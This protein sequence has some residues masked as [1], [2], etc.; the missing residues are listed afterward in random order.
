MTTPTQEMPPAQN[1]PVG[2]DTHHAHGGDFASAIAPLNEPPTGNEP[3]QSWQNPLSQR[4]ASKEMSHNFSNA[5]RFKT[6]R[7]LWLNL[8]IA[9]KELGLDIPQEAIDQMRANLDLDDDQMKEASEEERKTRHDVMAH[10]HVFKRKCPAAE[11]IIHLGVTSCYVTDNADLIFIK[12]AFDL[13]IP[14]LAIAISRLTKFAQEYS[15]MPTLGY[16][17]MQPAQL[18]TV[19]KRACLWIQDLLWDLRNFQRARDDLGFRGVKGTTGTQASFMS[20]FNNDHAKIK[21]LD[22]RVT[23]LCG[24]S[25]A[26]PVTGQT[27]SRKVDVDVTHTL[28]SFSS[29]VTKLATDLRHLGFLQEIEEPFGKDQ[30]GSSAMPYK[31]NPMLSERMCGLAR[32]LGNI[33]NNARETAGLMWME[34]T[35]DD[36]SNRRL[37]LPEAFLTA[38]ILLLV[39]QN[40]TEGL[41]VYPKM[42]ERHINEKLPYM[43]SENIIMAIVQAGGSRQDAHEELRV[44]SHQ[45]TNRVKNE[46]LELDLVERIRNS[47][48]FAPIHDQLDVLL[49]PKTFVG[50]APEQVDDFVEEWVTPALAPYAEQLASASAAELSV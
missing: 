36:S 32:W 43:A 9:Q 39:L 3:W 49:D 27:Y 40:V 26:Y 42:I 37:V 6:W 20:L 34:R 33:P 15:R 23:Q 38:D 44:L 13:I 10:V 18:T 28:S 35:L 19:G 22:K 48:F 50:R 41:V 2:S 4:Y 5:M 12:K 7:F 30:V 14:K 46:G 24:F 1:P 31:R 29:S 45:A 8:A 25:Y 17:H 21:A 16:T 11:R 47:K